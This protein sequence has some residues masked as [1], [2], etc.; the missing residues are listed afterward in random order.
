M[1]SRRCRGIAGALSLCALGLLVAGC[2]GGDTP[3]EV[4]E[5]SERVT[6][7][8][9]LED[10]I[11][12]QGELLSM[13]DAQLA[14]QAQ[15]LRRLRKTPSSAPL[16]QLIHVEKIEIDR[17]S[18]GYDE[19]RD[20]RPDGIRIYLR[21]YDQFG[22]YLRASGRIHVKLLD[23][24]APAQNQLVGEAKWDNSELADLWYGALLSSSHYTLSV[25]W[26]NP[27][28]PP[29]GKTITALVTFTDML[30]NR[31]FDAQR[32]IDVIPLSP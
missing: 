21:P 12:T 19:N 20:G 1:S 32:A 26:R 14:D 28:S 27:Q 15:E 9:E 7:I 25:P 5:S 3:E 30:S 18:G 10:K 6:R 16:D 31:V 24:S 22:G 8:Q 23:L 11:R 4:R 29:I 17:L 13:K 2:F